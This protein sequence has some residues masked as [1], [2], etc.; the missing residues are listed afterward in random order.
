MRWK[1]KASMKIFFQR[2]ADSLF[3]FL[4]PCW[5]WWLDKEWISQTWL[6]TVGRAWVTQR[7]QSRDLPTEL[8]CS[9]LNSSQ[10]IVSRYFRSSG[11]YF[12]E[13]LFF[14]LFCFDFS[15]TW[16]CEF[17]EVTEVDTSAQEG[18]DSLISFLTPVCSWDITVTHRQSTQ[19][20]K[21]Y[22][23]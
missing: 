15:K 7:L 20:K 9:P 12:F 16:S 1:Q 10:I 13:N 18:K 11:K 21:K 19:G 8:D 6:C 4:H 3:H 23:C 14:V 17:T 5:H 22:F 2:I